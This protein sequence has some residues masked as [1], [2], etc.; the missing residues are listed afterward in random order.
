MKKGIFIGIGIV[1]LLMAGLFS[2][3][4]EGKSDVQV[5]YL[6]P[7]DQ[8]GCM[9]IHFNQADKEALVIVNDELI[10]EFPERGGLP[11]SSSADI[12]L[13]LGWHSQKAFLIDDKGERIGEIDSGK[14]GEGSMSSTGF[15]SE[16]ARYSKSFDGRSSS[17]D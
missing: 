12:I 2:W 4:Y 16:N 13:D 3:L 8:T 11:T 1:L 7:D 6:V 5:T 15:S 10:I 17:C 9:S 14:I